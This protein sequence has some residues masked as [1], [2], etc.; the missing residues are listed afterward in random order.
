MLLFV[1]L[2]ES[3]IL[4]YKEI[5]QQTERDIQEIILEIVK[6]ELAIC[7]DYLLLVMRKYLVKGKSFG[8]EPKEAIKH[9]IKLFKERF[10]KKIR[11]KDNVMCEK[12]TFLT[13]CVVSATM[14]NI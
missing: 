10:V 1:L 13:K 4:A 2:G 3:T 6:N 9:K 11:V 12:K 5:E 7:L 8:D 14:K